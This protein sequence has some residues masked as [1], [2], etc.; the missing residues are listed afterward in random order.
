MM[1]HTTDFVLECYDCGQMSEYT[2]GSDIPL[3]NLDIDA[4][5][6]IMNDE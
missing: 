5:T 3:Q 4:V 2:V 1:A 6:K